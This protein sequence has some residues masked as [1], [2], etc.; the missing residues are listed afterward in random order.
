[1]TTIAWCVVGAI[2]VVQVIMIL[3]RRADRNREYKQ[4]L[5][6]LLKARKLKERMR[7]RGSNG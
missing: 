3:E 6:S 4:A 2:A 5:R 7:R 1:M